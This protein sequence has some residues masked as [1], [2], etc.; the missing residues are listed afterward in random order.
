MQH[1][2]NNQKKK[3][4]ELTNLICA[5]QNRHCYSA[6]RHTTKPKL[7]GGLAYITVNNGDNPPTT[8]LNKDDMNNTLHDYSRIHFATA[9][10]T[11]FMVEPLTHLL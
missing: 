4:K 11:P 6:F 9:Q 7:Q 1:G 5:E 2:A 8:I 3:S 10:G